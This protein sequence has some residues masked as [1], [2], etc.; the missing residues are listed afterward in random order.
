M[1]KETEVYL[2]HILESIQSID[3]YLDHLTF[4]DFKKRKVIIDAVI[5]R[6]EIMGEAVRQMPIDFKKKYPDVPWR[7]IADMR[8]YLIHE[9]FGVDINEVWRTIK[10]DLPV[11][12]EKISEILK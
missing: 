9:Y 12:K 7:D 10:D 1:A 11:F 5:R 2:G 6:F 8:N 4:D 3:E